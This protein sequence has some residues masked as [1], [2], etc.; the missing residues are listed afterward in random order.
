MA[1]AGG[2][3]AAA[4]IGIIVGIVVCLALS[5]TAAYKGY[6]AIQTSEEDFDKYGQ[7]SPI[8]EM[9]TVGGSS[10]IYEAGSGSDYVRL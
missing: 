6:Q 3:G 8:Y 9:G 10:A 4:I 7:S 2:L 5:G 1:V